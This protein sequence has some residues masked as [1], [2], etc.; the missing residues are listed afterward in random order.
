MLMD[1]KNLSELELR[2]TISSFK[3]GK[4]R[5]GVCFG[6][7]ARVAAQCPVEAYR[8][9]PANFAHASFRNDPFAVSIANTFTFLRSGF[10]RTPP[11]ISPKMRDDL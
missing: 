6:Y 11:L 3:E 1:M 7:S 5:K 8:L 4:F 10:S 2:C 9:A